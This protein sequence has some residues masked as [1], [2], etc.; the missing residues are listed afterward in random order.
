MSSDRLLTCPFCKKKY[1]RADLIKHLEKHMDLLP[2]GFSPLRM[3][4]HV[5]NNKPTTYVRPCRICRKPTDWDE[6]KGR[7]NFLCNNKSC[8]NKWVKIMKDTMGDK[9][10]AY[11]P[12]ASPEGLEK[13]LQGRKISGKYKFKDGVEFPYTGSYELET[14]KFMDLVL[15]CK[16]EDIEIPA[17]VIKYPYKGSEHI[18][19]PDIY[20]R[21]YNLII[22]VKDGGNN[23]NG[24]SGY[25]DTR[26]RQAA[27]EEYVIKHTDYNYLRL[28]DKNFS[29]LL[30]VFADLKMHLIE[31]NN[32]RVIHVN[33]ATSNEDN[34]ISYSSSFSD[35]MNIDLSINEA[36]IESVLEKDHEQK[37][38][39]SLSE[40]K[41]VPIDEKFL[42]EFT[43]KTK[44]LKEADKSEFGFGWLD[45]DNNLVGYVMCNDWGWITAVE[46]SNQYKQYGLGKQLLKYAIDHMGGNRLGVH[47]NNEVAKRL[48]RSMGF[49][50]VSAKSINGSG[51]KGMI[52]MTNDKSIKESTPIA[53]FAPMVSMKN[54][55][56]IIANYGLN[57]VFSGGSRYAVSDTPQLKKLIYRDK[58]GYLRLTEDRSV[59]GDD[60]KTYIVKNKKNKINKIFSENLNKFVT[61]DFIYESV[62]DHLLDSED[63]IQFENGCQYYEDYYKESISIQESIKEYIKGGEDMDYYS[64]ALTF[65]VEHGINLSE[66]QLSMLKEAMNN[67]ERT[68][69]ILEDNL[70]KVTLDDYPLNEITEED[71]E[72]NKKLHPVYVMLWESDSAMGSFVKWV[73]EVEGWQYSHALIGFNAKL[74]NLYS[75]GADPKMKTAEGD[76][77][78]FNGVHIDSIKRYQMK[79]KASARNIKV[80]A[81]MADD[82]TYKAIKEA[83]QYYVNN[84][85]KTSYNMIDFLK[86]TLGISGRSFGNPG[87]FCSQFVANVLKYADVNISGKDPIWSTP[88][89]LGNSNK[90][91]NFF[92]VF[93]GDARNCNENL[94]NAKI[95]KLRQTVPYNDLNVRKTLTKE[96][97]EELHNPD[98]GKENYAKKFLKFKAGQKID[99]VKNLLG[100]NKELK[101]KTKAMEIPNVDKAAED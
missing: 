14:L 2:E 90:F 32:T 58:Q 55:D 89:D 38:K 44:L 92:T 86:K 64:E 22:E 96:E 101:P 63:Q 6:K 43:N 100:G 59:L 51:E 81:L 79:E 12:T 98:L 41:K 87:Q 7:Y 62:F 18:Y 95:E 73:G 53:S 4:F 5:A 71:I 72:M 21:P 49:R 24:H 97:K 25:A 69:R 65:F 54:N 1:N 33:E 16:S 67:K 37:G 74:T 19:I 40:F 15:D 66:D 8:H 27:K 91:S 28:T 56:I 57:N 47:E 30:G 39:R 52:F 78:K 99:Q 9:Y 94:I 85:G 17:P 83:A 26:A 77:V 84:S 80:I 45:S 35:I 68:F 23:K 3:A 70:P 10:G 88:S 93:E 48:Y 82:R 34:N 11:R 20:Y 13:M 36:T 60:Y 75:F 31:N 46:V 50:E 76:Y 42:K 61:K 29:Q